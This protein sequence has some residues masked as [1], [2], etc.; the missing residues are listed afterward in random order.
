MKNYPLGQATTL[1]EK[2]L[3]SQ[4]YIPMALKW[5]GKLWFLQ[6]FAM[7]IYKG[8]GMFTIGWVQ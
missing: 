3:S 8:N 6:S 4:I 7:D 2:V 5:A 1:R